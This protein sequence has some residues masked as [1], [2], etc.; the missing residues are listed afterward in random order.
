MKAPE[1]ERRFGAGD[2][3]LAAGSVARELYVV[4]TGS[5]RFERAEG[6]E[7]SVEG[8]GTL[9]GEL[10]SILGVPSPYQVSAEEDVSVLVLDLSLVNRLCRESPEFSCRLIRHL[11]QAAAGSRTRAASVPAQR[12]D[13]SDLEALAEVILARIDRS[14]TPAPVEATLRDLAR[15]SGMGVEEAYRA[16][17]ILLEEGSAKLADDQL[18]LHDVVALERLSS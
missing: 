16:L 10:S 9:F 4:Q 5:V 11:A 1:I 12:G 2:C 18:V 14:S 3:I 7:G 8:P 13:R 17:H 15:E 6:T